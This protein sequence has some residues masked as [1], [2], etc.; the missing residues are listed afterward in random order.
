MSWSFFWCF[1]EVRRW[2]VWRAY[3]CKEEDFDFRDFAV[4]WWEIGGG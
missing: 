3:G 1:S 2:A 4:G